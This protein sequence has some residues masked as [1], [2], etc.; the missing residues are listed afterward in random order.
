MCER[1]LPADALVIRPGLIVGPHDPTDRFTYWPARIA[2]GGRALAP[3]RRDRIVQFI[4][5]RDLAAWL[6]RSIESGASGVYNAAG[7]GVTM[8][9]FLMTCTSV[10]GGTMAMSWVSD[11]VL[12]KAGVEPYTEIPLWIPGVDDGFDVKK[13]VA[14]GLVFRPPAE[15]VRDTLAWDRTR[16]AEAPRRAGL[17]RQ[18][19]R[20][21]LEARKR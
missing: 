3:G 10:C 5:A 15:T 21:L 19:E 9:E 14:A 20:E 8:T 1:T 12:L 2:R 18:R 4:D 6:V 16:P 11:D 7:P 17:T 13:A